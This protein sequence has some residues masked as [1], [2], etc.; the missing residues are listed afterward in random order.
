[1]PVDDGLVLVMG[2]VEGHDSH[3]A[4]LMQELRAVTR[5]AAC[6]KRNPAT[7]L[8]CASD[9]L[10]RI[11]SDLLATALVI[12]IDLGT[13]VA[14][15]ASA[16]HLAPSLLRPT[17][18]GTVLSPME[19]ETGPPL[20]I[21]QEWDERCTLLPADAVLFLYTDGLVETRADDIDAGIRRLGEVLE[22]VPS[23][24]ARSST[25]PSSSIR[26][27]I[28]TTL[29]SWSHTS[30]RAAIRPRTTGP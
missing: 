14:T 16:G 6:E 21:G 19:L 30:P 17:G 20:G 15:A 13:R 3:A 2:D 26:A 28:K 1:M 8:A 5:A 9:W 18:A 11:D 25:T 12:H 7:V 23:M 24:L 29:P 22:A 10:D 27:R 4:A